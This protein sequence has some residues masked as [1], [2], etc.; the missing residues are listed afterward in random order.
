MLTVDCCSAPSLRF[1]RELASSARK[2]FYVE[3]CSTCGAI[4]LHARN[5]IAMGEDFEEVEFDTFAQVTPEE[6]ARLPH[7]PTD[8]DLAFLADRRVLSASAGILHERKGWQ[9]P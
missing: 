3:S 8:A 5:E 7:A 9:W 2:D 1:V 6:A 4:W